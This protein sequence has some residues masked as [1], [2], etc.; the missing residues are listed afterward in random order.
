MTN[1]TTP[2]PQPTNGKDN[3]AKLV[4]RNIVT[5][6]SQFVR[7]EITQEQRESIYD[8]CYEIILNQTN[9]SKKSSLLAEV[10]EKIRVLNKKHFF[11]IDSP[12]EEKVLI[13][14]RA[15]TDVTTIIKEMNR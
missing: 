13:Y 5:A 11:K 8:D 4:V 3:L 7:G 15:L 6:T 14:N 12:A 2:T 9:H 10:E 1:K